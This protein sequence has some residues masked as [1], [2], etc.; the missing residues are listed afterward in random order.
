[1]SFPVAVYKKSSDDKAT[2]LA[3]LVSYYAFF[4]IFPLLL[5]LVTVLSVVLK[6]N[7]ELRQQIIDSAL[8]QFPLLGSQ[9]K[10]NVDPLEASGLALLVGLV[11]TFLGARGMANAFRTSCDTVWAVPR[12]LRRVGLIGFLIGLTILVAVGGGLVA[13]SVASGWAVSTLDIGTTGRLAGILLAGILNIGVFAVSFRLATSPVIPFRAMRLSAVLAAACW[14]ALQIVGGFY[15]TRQVSRASD[16]YG[17]FALVIGSMA[18]L[19][20]SAYLTVLCLEV[21]AVRVRHLWPR[22][23]LR[24]R[25]P[26]CLRTNGRS[27]PTPS[28][29][30]DRTHSRSRSSSIR[31]DGLWQFGHPLSLPVPWERPTWV[32]GSVPSPAFAKWRST[33]HPPAAAAR[34]QVVGSGQTK[35]S[36]ARACGRVVDADVGPRCARCGGLSRFRVTQ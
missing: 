35:R 22:R 32:H 12:K 29:S 4:A 24:P 1:M 21:D 34:R 16:L 31:R 3:A 10:E 36:W 14:T 9:L 19:Y 7:D 27:R 13:T 6:N 15:V 2:Q 23:L 25:P 26:H 17:V 28:P 11:G 18:F 30:G 33:S 5:V 8:G 20:L